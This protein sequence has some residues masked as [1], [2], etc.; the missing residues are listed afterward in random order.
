MNILSKITC[1]VNRYLNG[2]LYYINKEGK[3]N[4]PN[5]IDIKGKRD[6][7][8]LKSYK[9]GG[10]VVD[11]NER[12]YAY[13]NYEFKE[14]KNYLT[15]KT[16]YF[17]SENG[18]SSKNFLI[19]IDN[20]LKSK[21]LIDINGLEV[22]SIK[23]KLFDIDKIV[24]S[25]TEVNNNLIK[26]IKKIFPKLKIITFNNC[27]ILQDTSFEKINASIEFYECN[28]DDIIV[29]RNTKSNFDIW[30]SNINKVTT[31]N[32]MSS[33]IKFWSIGSR[34]H[35]PL[36]EIFLKCNFPNL[37]YLGIYCD[38]NPC[39]SHEKNFFFLPF[40]APNLETL[41]IEGKVYDLDFLSRLKYIN[42]ASICGKIDN[43]GYD[44]RV[45]YITNGKERKKL[46]EKNKNMVEYLKK[47]YPYLPL[48][49]LSSK[50]E[51]LRI[52]NLADTYYLIQP[53]YK[54]ELEDLIKNGPIN[55]NIPFNQKVKNYMLMKYNKLEHKIRNEYDLVESKYS[56]YNNI[57]YEE[58]VWKCNKI[59][60]TKPF[61]Y[62]SSGVPIIFDMYSKIK[63][64]KIEELNEPNDEDRFFDLEKTRKEEIE[65]E[66]I[67]TKFH[68]YV[69]IVSTIDELGYKLRS[70]DFS[71]SSPF[72][73]R[74]VELEK[75]IDEV[76]DYLIE[77]EKKY[78]N[79]LLIV[80]D[81]IYDKLTI[82]EKMFILKEIENEKFIIIRVSLDLDAKYD[83]DEEGLFDSI[84]EKS[85]GRYKKAINN[86]RKNYKK[87]IIPRKKEL[88]DTNVEEEMKKVKEYV[89]KHNRVK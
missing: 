85:D 31:C 13:Y 53:K 67:N 48:D 60:K 10:V 33:S 4:T 14:N 70:G 29:F 38:K 75:R 5:N 88:L 72:I 37:N 62:H 26:N 65:N 58:N 68:Y 23:S 76:Y 35:I 2:E 36:K 73:S 16:L 87:Y 51:F 49:T 79:D 24:I 82:K 20:V 28:I 3:I 1:D 8:F 89:L 43:S 56:I 52:L 54:N 34:Y 21:K 77:E 50:A 84:N 41:I 59:V 42:A 64:K 22:K 6:I 57:M 69:D 46:E 66:I 27:H 18:D 25:S 81:D 63:P 86:I 71:K 11:N 15:S 74:L 47:A 12:F 55:F 61:I 45:P 44:F 32:I 30:Y 7:R 83:I 80:L 78:Y 9:D 17:Q 39:R 40:S 19:F